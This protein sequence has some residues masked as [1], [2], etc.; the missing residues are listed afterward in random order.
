MAQTVIYDYIGFISDG[1][2]PDPWSKVW[3]FDINDAV[4]ITLHQIVVYI[5]ILAPFVGRN[6]SI[7]NKMQT[8]R[9]SSYLATLG[10]KGIYIPM[11][12]FPVHWG[13][14]D[15]D[16]APQGTGDVEGCSLGNIVAIPNM[17]VT[18]RTRLVVPFGCTG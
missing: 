16:C 10:H 7:L 15:L 2:R 5:A 11:C 6:I 9:V 13:R 1:S 12:T 8:F 3:N 18:D 4:G 14:S 17:F